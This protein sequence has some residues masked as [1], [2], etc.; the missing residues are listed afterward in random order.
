MLTTLLAYD[1]ALFKFI[2]SAHTPGWDL[3]FHFMTQLGNGWIMG[4]LLILAILSNTHKKALTRSLIMS[5]CILLSCGLLNSAIKKSVRRPRPL[6]H[7]SIEQQDYKVH[8]VGKRL[9]NRR[10]FP[11]GHTVTVFAA[12]ALL[13]ALYGGIFYLAFIVALISG[14]SRIYIGVHFPLDVLAGALLA[15]LYT[16][17]AV[18]LTGLHLLARGS[19]FK[20]TENA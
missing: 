17:I 1:S 6:K 12:A 20:P 11:S 15:T 14:Y 13:A 8:F 4:P 10:S 3:F 18:R 19:L 5:A 16:F 7:F 9:A 2:N